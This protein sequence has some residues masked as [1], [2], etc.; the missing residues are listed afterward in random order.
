MSTQ[1]LTEPLHLQMKQFTLYKHVL[2]QLITKIMVQQA[3]KVRL[4]K[5][6]KKHDEEINTSTAGSLCVGYPS[7]Q[8]TLQGT[9]CS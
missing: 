6:L 4:S 9:K 1:L 2:P 5:M 7:T 8:R 3:C